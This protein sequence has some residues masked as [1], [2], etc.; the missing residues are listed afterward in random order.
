V[1]E[2]SILRAAVDGGRFGAALGFVGLLAVIFIGMATTVL[3][4]VYGEPDKD[5]QGTGQDESPFMTLA[6]ILL[7][8]A[9]VFFGLWLPDWLT[10]VLGDAAKL[11]DGGAS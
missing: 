9:V 11:L 5:P 2:F 3:S 6:P 1:S 7:M 4:V 8:G 10:S